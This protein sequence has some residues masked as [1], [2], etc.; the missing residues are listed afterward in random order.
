MARIIRKCPSFS[1]VSAG[2]TATLEIKL[3][4]SY[5]LMHLY[6]TGVTLA[7]MKNIRIEAD[8]KPIDRMSVV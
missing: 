1:N 5:H 6:F 3:G 7:Q 8:G 2:S 4:L